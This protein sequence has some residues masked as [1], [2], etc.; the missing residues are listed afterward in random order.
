MGRNLSARQW[1]RI[2]RARDCRPELVSD[3]ASRSDVV[4]KAA[5]TS[6]TIPYHYI[7]HVV[8]AQ[9]RY[10]ASAP[11]LN[12]VDPLTILVT[13]LVLTP[14]QARIG[15]FILCGRVP[16]ALR[17]DYAPRA[18]SLVHAITVFVWRPCI[19]PPPLPPWG[20]TH[21][22]GHTSSFGVLIDVG[23][24]MFTPSSLWML[25]R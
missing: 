5:D 1:L 20:A 23:D 17:P 12:C 13:A 4:S 25:T 22:C 9:L 6:V 14:S 11:L 3:F 15:G 10:R 16:S 19:V 2:A 8:D 7:S 18:C 24:P 21:G